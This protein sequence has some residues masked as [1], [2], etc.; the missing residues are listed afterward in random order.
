MSHQ[1]SPVLQ[2]GSEGKNWKVALD[3]AV[4]QSVVTSECRR[5]RAVLELCVRRATSSSCEESSKKGRKERRQW[6]GQEAWP[7]EWFCHHYL[8]VFACVSI[9][10][11][12]KAW[13]MFIGHNEGTISEK[14]K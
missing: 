3:L 8:Q 7:G 13:N 5:P 14:V 9:C 12:C 10:L 1:A 2:R 4:K 11:Y 6:L